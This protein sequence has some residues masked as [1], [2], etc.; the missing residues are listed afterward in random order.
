M[1]D[2]RPDFMGL[3]VWLPALCCTSPCSPA[4]SPAP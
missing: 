2:S 3:P 4:T 1:R